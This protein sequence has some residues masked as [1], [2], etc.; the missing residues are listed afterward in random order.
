[1]SAPR[2]LTVER[3]QQLL[4]ELPPHHLV[5]VLLPAAQL[6]GPAGAWDV[7]LSGDVV[8][9]TRADHGTVELQLGQVG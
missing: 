2:A 9:V 1:M 7:D 6:D 4:S 5:T 3:L 8:D